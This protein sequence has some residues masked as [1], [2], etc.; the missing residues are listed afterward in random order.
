[1]SNVSTATASDAKRTFKNIPF[2]N[3]NKLIFGYLNINYL[4]NK[5]DLLCEKIKGSIYVFMI[6]ETKL[7]DS[8]PQ[9]QFLI[10]GFQINYMLYKFQKHQLH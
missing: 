3:N 5:F 9:G 4:K 6:L 1:M 10:E 8:F 2:S 7:D